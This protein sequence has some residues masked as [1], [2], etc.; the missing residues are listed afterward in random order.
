MKCEQVIVGINILFHNV[1]THLNDYSGLT[2][3]LYG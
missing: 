2:S 3:T 1:I